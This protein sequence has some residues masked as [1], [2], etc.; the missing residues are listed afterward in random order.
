MS[1]EGEDEAEDMLIQDQETHDREQVDA[2]NQEIDAENVVL[3]VDRDFFLSTRDIN[4]GR[5]AITKVCPSAWLAGIISQFI[6]C[7]AF[8]EDIQ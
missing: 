7:S 3:D 8:E 4:L 2:L 6:D 1:D 5:F